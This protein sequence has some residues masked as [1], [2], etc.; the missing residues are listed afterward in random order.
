MDPYYEWL[1]IPAEDQPPNHYRLLGINLFESNP[2]VIE[3]AVNQRMGYLQ[4]LSG[5]QAY[6]EHAQ[7]IM[8]E[9]SR[10][11]LILLNKEKKALYDKSIARGRES[12]PEDN[13]NPTED[14]TNPRAPKSTGNKSAKP[15]LRERRQ[16]SGA[17][18][19]H[20]LAT[21][22]AKQRHNNEKPAVSF[23]NRLYAVAGIAIAI[24]MIV[25][26]FVIQSGNELPE[27]L[28][29]TQ[30]QNE[31]Q[32]ESQDSKPP[33]KPRGIRKII[34]SDVNSSPKPA[35]PSTDSKPPVADQEKP[36]KEDTKGP[37]ESLEKPKVNSTGKPNTAEED[38]SDKKR[39]YEWKEEGFKEVKADENGEL[40]AKAN[41]NATPDKETI[42]FRFLSTEQD[43]KNHPKI[44]LLGLFNDWGKYSNE[45]E[46]GG[47]ETA[48]TLKNQSDKSSAWFEGEIKKR[49]ITSKT[50]LYKFYLLETGQYEPW[51]GTDNNLTANFS[52]SDPI[53]DLPPHHPE[54]D[55]DWRVIGYFNAWN[56][57]KGIAKSQGENQKWYFDFSDEFKFKLSKRPRYEPNNKDTETWWPRG[58]GGNKNNIMVGA[59]L[60]KLE[61]KP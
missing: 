5:D 4:Q 32:T 51:G 1:G 7:R 57:E 16:P 59:V 60:E 55:K 38:D 50:L 6:V 44:Y 28:I 10:V 54:P 39:R 14:T 15:P 61:Q 36:E 56:E 22:R 49:F 53:I 20:I 52:F 34:D 29:L 31:K 47:N 25:F 19:S 37:P 30:A 17:G 43:W 45:Q 35:T 8:G 33:A 18:Q 9:I 26:L 11:R 24:L 41:V 12:L 46:K 58:E 13:D 40:W 2:Q 48:Y 21:K 42:T 3:S 23:D 27:N